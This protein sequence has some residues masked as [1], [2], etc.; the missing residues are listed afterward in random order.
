MSGAAVK[1]IVL[2]LAFL[3]SGGCA[4][5]ADR[6]INQTVIPPPY[7]V[8]AEAQRVHQSL[9]IADLHAD[10]LLWGRDLLRRASYGH[11]DLP[12]LREGN[13]GLQVFSAVTRVPLFLRLN[14]NCDRPDVIGTLMCCQ[15]RPEGY[16]SLL[17]RALY[18][19]KKLQDWIER[20]QG[21][22]RPILSRQD[23]EELLAARGRG[24]AVIGA[25]LS[26]EGAQ[27]LEGDLANLD[28][29]CAQGFRIIGLNHFFDNEFSGSAHG[30]TKGGLTPLGKALV[31]A[32]EEKGILIDLAHASPKAI[33]DTLALA[34][35][36]VIVSHGGAR[37]I[38][39]SVRNL[40]DSQI[41]AIADKG[42]VIGIGL[43]KSATG[44]K[45]IAGTVRSMRYVADLAGIDH[46]ALGS[47]WDGSKAVIA[48][49]GLGL[50]TESL[51]K[52]GFSQE[53]IAAILGGNVLRVLRATLP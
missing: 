50:L 25:L 46:V 51:M 10:T 53:E 4:T 49:S 34:S 38:C 43:F 3:G 36:L 22:L 21:E 9:F 32:A 7:V 20:S 31:L 5:L 14:N 45:D 15:G 29:L 18:Q 37:G 28:R 6:L 1:S 30:K 23:L 41:R 24:E 8:Q 42:G 44:T 12:R 17:G 52:A 2:I 33:D 48:A 26:L 35:K 39:D 47:D 11:V 27:A 13:V 16:E 19:G 40:S